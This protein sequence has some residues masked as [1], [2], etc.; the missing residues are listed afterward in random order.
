M[1]KIFAAAIFGAAVLALSACSGLRWSGH[2]AETKSPTPG[3]VVPGGHDVRS[4]GLPLHDSG[5]RSPV[6]NLPDRPGPHA[7]NALLYAQ[8][9]DQFRQEAAT[10]LT[11]KQLYAGDAEMTAHCDALI[12]Q[13]AA[14][15]D[16]YQ[17]VSKLHDKRAEEYNGALLKEL[18]RSERRTS[19]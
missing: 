18:R 6:Y 17:A 8:K 2:S 15:A 13:L 16:E 10:H 7:V 19:P 14:L 3:R 4:H 11:M 1:I 12:K 9:A 5:G